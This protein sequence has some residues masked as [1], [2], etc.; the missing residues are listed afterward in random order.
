MRIEIQITLGLVRQGDDMIHDGLNYVVTSDT[1]SL[2]FQI[3]NQDGMMNEAGADLITTTLVES[4]CAHI[5]AC[6]QYGLRNDA[7][8]LRNVISE[9]ERGFVIAQAESKMT[10]TKGK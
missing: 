7:E 3:A 10:V 1:N 8:H 9:L 2:P 4:L 5:H 6:N